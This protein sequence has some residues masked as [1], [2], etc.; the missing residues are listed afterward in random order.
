MAMDVDLSV[1]MLWENRWITHTFSAYF[2][3]PTK[4]G[5]AYSALAYFGSPTKYGLAYS[6]LALVLARIAWI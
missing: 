4:Y 5:L 3:L 6:A 1:E 2:G